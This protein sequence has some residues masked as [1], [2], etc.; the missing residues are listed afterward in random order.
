[1]SIR[2]AAAAA[3]VTVLI[4]AACSPSGGEGGSDGGGGGDCHVGMAWATFQEER[5]GLRDLPGLEAALEEGGATLTDNDAANS[6]ETQASNVEALFD[7]GIDVLILNSAEPESS[8]QSVEAA[9]DAGIPVIAYD[10]ELESADALF[11]THDNVGVGRMIAEAVTAAQPTGNYAIIKGQEGQTNPLFLRE[12][13]AEVIDPLIDAGDITIP[14]GAEVY[15]DEWLPDNAQDNME[16]IL[17]ANDN[18]IQAVLVQ[19]DGMAGG[20]IA[21]LAAQGLDGEVAVGGQDGDVAAINRV[22]LGTQVVSVLKDATELG[23]AAGEAALQLCENP[24]I[25]AVE[26]AVES[27]TVGGIEG[28]AV[29]LDP[30]PITQDNLQDALDLEWLTEEEL[31]ADVPSGTVD[32]CP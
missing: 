22:A 21:A 32:V 27:T 15:T 7:A 12:G 24:D 23:R 30:L 6:A 29:L 9:V 10:R 31:C 16:T 1:V 18:D 2:R 3:S 5:Y 11:M 19:N 20:V 13:F 26:G 28:Y 14:E 17:T 4:L 8:L 25:S